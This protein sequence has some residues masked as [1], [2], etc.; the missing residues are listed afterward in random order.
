MKRAKDE[1]NATVLVGK[2]TQTKACPKFYEQGWQRDAGERFGD[3]SATHV[4]ILVVFSIFK[5]LYFKSIIWG[6]S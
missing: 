4:S 5:M 6:N 2:G 3:D 1:L